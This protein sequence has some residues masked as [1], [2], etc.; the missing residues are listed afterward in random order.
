MDT[1][2]AL[3]AAHEL[4]QRLAARR[5]RRCVAGVV[6]ELA[7]GARQKNRVVLLEIGLVDVGRVDK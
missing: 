1:G 6:Q 3:A 7:G 4:E 5:G 2:Q